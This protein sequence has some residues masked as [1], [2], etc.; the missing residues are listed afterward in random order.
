MLPEQKLIL[1]TSQEISPFFLGLGLSWGGGIGGGGRSMSGGFPVLCP[2]TNGRLYHREIKWYFLCSCLL[3]IWTIPRMR[4][5]ISLLFW[6]GMSL[7]VS[8]AVR[9]FWSKIFTSIPVKTIK[10]TVKHFS[11]LLFICNNLKDDYQFPLNSQWWTTL[12]HWFT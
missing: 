11:T 5:A 6:E 12:W 10:S 8:S 7:T 1:K 3:Y 2:A 4:A 9:P